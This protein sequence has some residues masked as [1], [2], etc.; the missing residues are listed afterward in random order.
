MVTDIK[1]LKKVKV[2]NIRRDIK[3]VPAAAYCGQALLFIHMLIL[4][5]ENVI[6]LY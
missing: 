1:I 5:N 4:R 6:R 3:E 2:N